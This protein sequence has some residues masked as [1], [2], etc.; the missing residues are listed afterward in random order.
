MIERGNHNVEEPSRN[1]KRIVRP[2]RDT[3]RHGV[4]VLAGEDERHRRGRVDGR[5]LGAST[6]ARSDAALGGSRSR[7]A[8]QNRRARNWIVAAP[9]D[10]ASAPFRSGGVRAANLDPRNLRLVETWLGRPPQAPIQMLIDS[11]GLCRT[12]AVPGSDGGMPSDPRAGQRG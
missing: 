2:A 12:G 7:I 4:G 11:G 5:R 10:S 3:V 8:P 1:A 9:G 6:R